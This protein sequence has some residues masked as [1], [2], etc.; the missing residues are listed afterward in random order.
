MRNPV[1]K[2]PRLVATLALLAAA[3]GCVVPEARYEEARSAI[4]VEQEAHRRTLTEL[5]GISESLGTR[6]KGIA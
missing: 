1:G 5:R 3:T 6:G 2:T 4:H